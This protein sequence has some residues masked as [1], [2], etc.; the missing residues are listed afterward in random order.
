MSEIQIRIANEQDTKE[1][2]Q[3]MYD[4]FTPLRN[5]G[6]NWPSV[7]ATLDVVRDNLKHNTTFVLENE[8]EII[9]TITVRY[10]WEITKQISGYLFV[11][12]FANP[13]FI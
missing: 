4:A 1:I 3:L 8:K 11:W 5:L 12:W 10:P 6:I 13:P 9:S 7:N 2:H